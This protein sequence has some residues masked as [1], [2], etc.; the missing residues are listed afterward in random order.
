MDV[1]SLLHVSVLV[2]GMHRV[3]F[4][5]LNVLSRFQLPGNPSQNNLIV[6]TILNANG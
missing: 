6:L 2:D 1:D 4:D 5:I 3:S